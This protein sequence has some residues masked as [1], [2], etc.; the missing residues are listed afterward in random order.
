M[1]Q[2]PAVVEAAPAVGGID[3]EA[4]R[5]SWP[6][7]LGRIYQMR[8][9]T[10]TFLSEHA[11]VLSYDG[12][13][14]V[15][16]IATVGLAN[17]F[18]MGSHAEVVRQ[19]LIDTLGVD[20]RVEGTL[21]D[22]GSMPAGGG[23]QATSAP[24]GA[25]AT[26]GGSG[27]SPGQGEAAGPRQSAPP[28]DVGVPAPSGSTSGSSGPDWGSGAADTSSAPAW[29]TAAPTP[30]PDVP[31]SPPETAAPREP[32]DS[33]VSDDDEDIVD[34]GAAGP[35]VIERILGGTVIREE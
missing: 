20:A 11:Q 10:W 15:L 13:R 1:E 8:R 27:G 34:A 32:D 26:A 23:S 6:D 35:A 4:L 28:S 9:A 29:A 17:A 14:L 25:P 21:H 22:I 33:S 24:A 31:S 19:A 30:A 2:E 18:R 5:R 16:G 3:V 7:V 12:Q